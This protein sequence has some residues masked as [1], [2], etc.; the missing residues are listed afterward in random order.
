MWAWPGGWA[1]SIRGRRRSKGE[2][3]ASRRRRAAGTGFGSFFVTRGGRRRIDVGRTAASNRGGLSRPECGPFRRGGSRLHQKGPRGFPVD[4]IQIPPNNAAG[5]CVKDP[6]PGALDLQDGGIVVER[7]MDKTWSGQPGVAFGPPHS[8]Q[9]KRKLLGQPLQGEQAKPAFWGGEILHGSRPGPL[10]SRCHFN[11]RQGAAAETGGRQSLQA[12][13]H[14]TA[15]VEQELPGQI[16]HFAGPAGFDRRIEFSQ[17]SK[18]HGRLRPAGQCRVAD[19]LAGAGGKKLCGFPG[20]TVMTQGRGVAAL[21]VII[22]GQLKA[23]RRRPTRAWV[24]ENEPFN[25]RKGCPRV[26]RKFLRQDSQQARRVRFHRRLLSDPHDGL[27]KKRASL[28]GGGRIASAGSGEGAGCRGGHG[29]A[30][31]QGCAVPQ[32]WENNRRQ[33]GAKG[34]L[35]D[36]FVEHVKSFGKL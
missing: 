19:G 14:S 28:D 26:G 17:V 13:L 10:L 16:G 8:N 4:R 31:S 36:N 27:R 3:T 29:S 2:S 25:R 12:L 15:P 35:D 22:G 24:F 7:K 1:P 30:A 18:T 11:E 21:R 32:R 5:G 9:L 23:Q 33:Q 34:P 6:G 20:T